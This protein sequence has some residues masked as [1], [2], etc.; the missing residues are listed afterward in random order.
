MLTDATTDVGHSGLMID[1]ETKAAI[2]YD[3][4][5]HTELRSAVKTEFTRSHELF[6]DN[7]KDLQKAYPQPEVAAPNK[8][9][10]DRRAMT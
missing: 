10:P 4:A 1:A 7:Q 8:S 5:T 3:F 2:L 9:G 6:A